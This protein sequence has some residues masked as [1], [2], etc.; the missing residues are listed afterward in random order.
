MSIAEE[1]AYALFERIARRL[2]AEAGEGRDWGTHVAIDPGTGEAW[3][4]RS[5]HVPVH[6]V[7]FEI[8]SKGTSYKWL[9]RCW[10]KLHPRGRGQLPFG[11]QSSKRAPEGAIE[12]TSA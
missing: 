12:R 7:A 10:G 5:G 3:R 6:L 4:M 1:D 8:P 9:M 2:A 11:E